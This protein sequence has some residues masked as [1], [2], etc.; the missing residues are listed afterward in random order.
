ML[1]VELGAVL[2]LELGA[3]LGVKL[4][5][6][7]GVKL[8]V[9]LGAKLGA[10]LG[11]KL[12]AV[13]GVKLGAVLGIELEAETI[14]GVSDDCF[15]DDFFDLGTFVVDLGTLLSDFFEVFR[16]PLPTLRVRLWVPRI[17]DF[18]YHKKLTN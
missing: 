10:V 16:E 13:L 18:S 8:G 5:A 11:A 6:V 7:L 17:C 12:G 1:G 3:V 2:G 15:S 14:I 9:V 4:G